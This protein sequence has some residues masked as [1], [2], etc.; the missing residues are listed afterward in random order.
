M[1]FCILN[2][3]YATFTALKTASTFAMKCHESLIDTCIHES[4]KST[5]KMRHGAAIVYRG[6]MV[7]VACNV[8]I[9]DSLPPPFSSIH[10]E[11]HVI[12]KFLERY[13]KKLLRHC[14]LVVIRVDRNGDL[15]NSR[16]CNNCHDYIVKNRVPKVIYST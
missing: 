2:K 14:T 10:A 16:P 11:V 9:C 7:A 5:M 12:R 6:R 3:D 13:P 15:R 1:S 4:H 8:S